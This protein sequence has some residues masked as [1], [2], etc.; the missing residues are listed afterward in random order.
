M[1]D[2]P[3]PLVRLT[4]AA[5]SGC[6]HARKRLVEELTPCVRKLVRAA[7]GFN[8]PAI[9]STVADALAWLLQD[10]PRI[11]A[12]D[13]EPEAYDRARV[14]MGRGIPPARSHRGLVATGARRSW[15]GDRPIGPEIASVDVP[16]EALSGR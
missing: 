5:Q 15:H 4:L 6:P 9:G 13:V 2:G 3:E 14:L 12:D 11:L 1:R 8:H 7:L 10:L 16:A